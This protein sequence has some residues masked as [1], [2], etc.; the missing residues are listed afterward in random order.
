MPLLAHARAHASE[1][2][3]RLS[4]GRIGTWQT[5]L[6][7]LSGGLIPC[8]AAITVFILCLHLGQF[9]LGV[10]LVSAFSLG[11]AL[12]LIGVGVVAALGLR[13]VS[14]RSLR[15][16]HLFDAAPW[17][18]AALIALVGVLILWTGLLHFIEIDLETW[19]GHSH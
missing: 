8:P 17:I 10:T 14:A 5:V 3:S 7:G 2:R 15:L 12:T 1:I 4:D 13:Y 11:L 9:W 16:T 19:H 6:F 18:S